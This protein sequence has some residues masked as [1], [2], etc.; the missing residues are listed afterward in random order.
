MI[1]EVFHL[2]LIIAGLVAVGF[3]G[4]GMWAHHSGGPYIPIWTLRQDALADRQMRERGLLARYDQL[5]QWA[6]DTAYPDRVALAREAIDPDVL[7]VLFPPPPPPAKPPTTA[8]IL[9]SECP[10]DSGGHIWDSTEI[11]EHGV[12]TVQIRHNCRRCHRS[13]TEAITPLHVDSE[14][15]VGNA[16]ALDPPKPMINGIPWGSMEEFQHAARRGSLLSEA[17]RRQ[18][19]EAINHLS[20]ELQVVLGRIVPQP[21]TQAFVMSVADHERIK[22]LVAQRQQIQALLANDQQVVAIT[23][24][25]SVPPP[26]PVSHL[27]SAAHPPADYDD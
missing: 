11:A 6:A 25:F 16:A 18:L 7:A 14:K 19:A 21:D 5:V 3:Y 13:T 17:N 9:T 15:V 22:Q 24:A 12:G 2:L 27:I 23:S 10:S 20:K 26:I 4:W 8:E 1:T